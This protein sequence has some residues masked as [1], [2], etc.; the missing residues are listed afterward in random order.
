MGCKWSYKIKEIILGV[1]PQKFKVRLV[2]KGLTQKVGINFTNV[3]SL[4]VRHSSLRIFL[5]FVAVN[6]MHLEQ[7]NI[8]IAFLYTELDEMIMMA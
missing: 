5:A 7:I 2:T 6:N 3:F 1:E 8:K 4:M